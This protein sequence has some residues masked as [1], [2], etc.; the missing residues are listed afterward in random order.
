M[1][2]IVTTTM[3]IV[4][5]RSLDLG[6]PLWIGGAPFSSPAH[7]ASVGFSGCMRNVTVNGQLLDLEDFLDQQ[8]SARGCESGCGSDTCGGGACIPRIDAYTCICPPQK[9]GENCKNS[10]FQ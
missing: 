5:V 3:F 2:T 4:L 10:E 7:F 6:L 1:T 9:T 8:N